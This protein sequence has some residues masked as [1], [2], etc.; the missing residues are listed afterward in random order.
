MLRLRVEIDSESQYYT[1]SSE[2]TWTLPNHGLYGCYL[3]Y[4]V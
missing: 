2:E 4:L 1:V 3:V